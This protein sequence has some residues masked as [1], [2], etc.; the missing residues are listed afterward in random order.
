MRT[1]LR[2]SA[3]LISCASTVTRRAPGRRH[4]AIS[5]TLPM[6]LPRSSTVAADGHHVVPYHAASTSSVE[7]RWPSRSWKMRKWP[8][9]K[10]SVSSGR[11]LRQVAR[12]GRDGA[13]RAQPRKVDMDRLTIAITN[14]ADSESPA[15]GE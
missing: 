12:A 14:Y 13:G 9:M 11:H 4:A 10:S 3:T 7:K 1:D 15:P 6:P 8:E 5:A 2:A